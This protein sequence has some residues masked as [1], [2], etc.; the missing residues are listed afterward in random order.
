M[1]FAPSH[2]RWSIAYWISR[3]GAAVGRFLPTSFWYALAVPIAGV[4]W[5]VM[6]RQRRIVT[7]NLAPVVGERAASRASRG[8]FRNYARYVIDFY[9]LPSLGRESLCGR[10]DFNEWPRLNAALTEGKGTIFVTLH[11]GQAELGAGAFSA[12]GYSISAICETFNHEGMNVFIQGLRT[13]LGM[14]VIPAKRAAPGMLRCLNRGEVLGMMFD[15]IEPSG[16]GVVVD[17]FGAPAEVS[18]APARIALRSGARV[19]P[20]VVG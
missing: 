14:K 5:L 17:F 8:V 1:R 10:I 13:R 16:G 9:Q 2:F 19:L 15:A 3:L 12:Y 7:A 18:A 6:A 11:L 4:C 20:G